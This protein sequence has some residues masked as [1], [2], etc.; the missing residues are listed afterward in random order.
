MTQ[1]EIEKVQSAIARY[2]ERQDKEMEAELNKLLLSVAKRA[3]TMNYF[4]RETYAAGIKAIIDKY[5]GKG[6]EAVQKLNDKVLDD[7]IKSSGLRETIDVQKIKK[8]LQGNTF[9]ETRY[10]LDPKTGKIKQIT[11]DKLAEFTS[12]FNLSGATRPMQVWSIGDIID[13]A[14]QEKEAQILGVVREGLA[15]GVDVKQITK[16]LEEHIN[17]TFVRGSWGPGLQKPP[18]KYTDI[19]DG[20]IADRISPQQAGKLAREQYY[21]ETGKRLTEQNNSY[22]KRLS[23]AGRDYRAIRITRTEMWTEYNNSQAETAR[24]NPAVDDGKAEIVL[25]KGR[26][27]WHCHCDDYAKEVRGGKYLGADGIFYD[28]KEHTKPVLYEGEP[29]GTPPY[30]P[31]CMCTI[32]PKFL[33]I[34]EFDAKMK[35]L[36]D[37]GAYDGEMKTGTDGVDIGGNPLSKLTNQ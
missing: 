9:K 24:N 11:S 36:L 10:V 28:D 3:V 13:K 16:D 4:D 27:S 23:G 5:S 22:I 20:L 7:A 26:D 35:K 25:E 37:S 14:A 15:T 33:S 6:A 2:L 19:Y 32:R 8:T 12:R 1:K 34:D 21:N 18:K 17:G 31:S 29:I 30:H